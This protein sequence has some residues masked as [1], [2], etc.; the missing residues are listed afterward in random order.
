[1]F[2]PFNFKKHERLILRKIWLSIRENGHMRMHLI[3]LIETY[4]IGLRD[5]VIKSINQEDGY[6]ILIG[7]EDG[8]AILWNV[9]QEARLRKRITESEYLEYA[10]V[11]AYKYW[12]FSEKENQKNPFEK[13]QELK[14]GIGRR[15]SEFLPWK[16][17]NS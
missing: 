10:S 1:M 6:Q 15:I 7:N 16:K 11:L 5:Q 2:Y 12:S 14:S 3:E 17:R 9:I 13:L 8:V 4:S